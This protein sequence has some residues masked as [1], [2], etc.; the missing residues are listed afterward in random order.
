MDGD[1]NFSNN[2]LE[3]G[4]FET[5]IIISKFVPSLTVEN[6]WGIHTNE[7]AQAHL[8]KALGGTYDSSIGPNYLQN[9]T[10]VDLY[11][12]IHFSKIWTML[13]LGKFILP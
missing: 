8:S 13:L 6:S 7:D 4:W 2:R 9:E 1:G 11:T 5:Y 10:N 12:Q 3:L